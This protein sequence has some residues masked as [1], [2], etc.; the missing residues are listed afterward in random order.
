MMPPTAEIPAA[1]TNG[2][3]I[4]SPQICKSEYVFTACTTAPTGC[5]NRRRGRRSVLFHVGRDVLVIVFLQPLQIKLVLVSAFGVLLKSTKVCTQGVQLLCLGTK[6]DRSPVCP[7]G[8]FPYQSLI[9]ELLIEFRVLEK[10]LCVQLR[11]IPKTRV[12][13]VFSTPI[14]CQR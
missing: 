6:Q 2:A 1:A 7:P 13:S 4:F 14:F 9:H 11:Q 5:R 12:S 8:V 3:T 10:I